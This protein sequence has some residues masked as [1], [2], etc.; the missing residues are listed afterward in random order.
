MDITNKG[1]G[2]WA[3]SKKNCLFNC[4]G[5]DICGGFECFGKNDWV[6]KSFYDID[7]HYA[8]TFKFNFYKIDKY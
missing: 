5:A 8:L 3:P 2:D 6:V 7:P 4:F 1:C